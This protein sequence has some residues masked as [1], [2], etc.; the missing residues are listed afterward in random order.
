MVGLFVLVFMRKDKADIYNAA[1][2]SA[3][4]VAV[5]VFGIVVRR[6]SEIRGRETREP[7]DC[8]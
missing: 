6:D 4:E 2:S 1:D 5:G 7:W 3:T 8:R